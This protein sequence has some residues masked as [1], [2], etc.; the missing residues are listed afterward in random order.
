VR[1]K[2][3]ERGRDRD[4]ATGRREKGRDRGKGGRKERKRG[5]G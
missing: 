2:R 5:E 1:R 4:G 3:R